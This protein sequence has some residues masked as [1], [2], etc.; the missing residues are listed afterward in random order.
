MLLDLQKHC[1]YI[2][3]N[4]NKMYVKGQE[5]F[6]FV[7]WVFKGWFKVVSSVFQ[8]RFMGIFSTFQGC[9]YILYSVVWY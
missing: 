2:V 5:D 8:G 1:G 4:S 9:L 3:R 7:S 6:K